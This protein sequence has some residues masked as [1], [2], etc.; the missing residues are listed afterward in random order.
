M[1][2]LPPENYK[3][4]HK[5]N[6]DHKINLF[7]GSRLVLWKGTFMQRNFEHNFSNHPKEIVVYVRD[8]AK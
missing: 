6:H 3:R 8:K 1:I 7:I 5:T 4:K 2:L